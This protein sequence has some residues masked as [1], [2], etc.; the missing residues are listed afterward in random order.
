MATKM[1]MVTATT[2]TTRRRRMGVKERN[3]CYFN[4][5]MLILYP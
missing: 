1:M 3:S 2:M 5:K 4:D